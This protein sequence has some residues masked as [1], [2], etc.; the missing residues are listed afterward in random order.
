MLQ[1]LS[2]Q[3]AKASLDAI[4]DFSGLGDAVENPVKTYSSGMRSRLGFSTA[5]LNHVDI[6]LIDEVLAVGDREF[7]AQAREAIRERFSDSRTV[8]LVSH[9]ADQL[10]DLCDR[11]MVVEAGT[12]RDCG[13]QMPQE[14]LPR[15]RT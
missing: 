13:T 15:A 10:R 2:R 9:S 1:G 8:V 12:S 5:L 14:Y 7:R 4:R 3:E 11:F 6:L